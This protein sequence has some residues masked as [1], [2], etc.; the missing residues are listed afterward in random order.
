M[1]SFRSR[2]ARGVLARGFDLTRGFEITPDSHIDDID[3]EGLR[4]RIDGMA[5]RQRLRGNVVNEAVD[6]G[7]VPAEWVVHPAAQADRVLVWLHG[8]AHCLC[9]PITHRRLAVSL[10][11][12]GRARVLLPDYGL[13]PEHPFPY[14]RD[15][16]VEVL[17]WLWEDQGVDPAST[18]LGGDSSGGGLAV[19][20]LLRLRDDALQ[21]PACAVLFSP[22]VDLAGAGPTVAERALR[23]PLLPFD[24]AQLPARAYAGELPL[25][26]PGVS[27][28]YA[29]LHGLPPLLAHVGTEEF[30]YDEVEL[31]VQ[32]VRAAGGQADLGVWQG[33][34]HVFQ[35]F[36]GTPEGRAAITE[37]GGFLQ[38]HTPV[39]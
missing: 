39:A 4:R 38:R 2:V 23:D 18:G 25:D 37:A 19:A 6:A 9:S 32:K 17:R 24:L 8:G 30:L 12:R 34:W 31:L 36:P 21:A 1:P 27:P 13:A 15:Q 7:G 16:V 22:W 10:S 35:A 3:V 33:Q 5:S 14:G 26:D 20:T 11:K 28:V 29:D